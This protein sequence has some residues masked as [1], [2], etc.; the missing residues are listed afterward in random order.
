VLAYGLEYAIL[1][2]ATALVA[3]AAGALAA[4]Y[5]V[6]RIM[7]FRFAFDPWTAGMA[8]GVAI[9]LTVAFGLIGTWRALGQKPA[10]VLRNL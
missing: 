10:P 3:S 5:I 2:L 9:L 6:E 7:R 4:A 1:G 8:A